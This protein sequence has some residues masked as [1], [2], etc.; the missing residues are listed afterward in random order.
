MIGGRQNRAGSPEPALSELRDEIVAHSG[1]GY[2]PCETATQTVPGDGNPEASVVFVGE[3]PGKNE[4]EQGRPFIGR[5]GKLLDELLAEAGLVR[6]DVWITNVVKA[7]PPKNRDPKAPEIAHW[8]PFLEREL[9][10][11]QPQ[12]IVPLGRHAL[13]H[14]APT[15]KIG[16]V[17]GTL[18]EAR[19][20]PL[21]HPAA[22]MY[23]QTLKSTLFEDA[24]ALGALLSR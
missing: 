18:I 5:A 2:E 11:I 20:F 9:E 15:A 1:C 12:L 16:E 23:N 22:A 19:V 21:Y 24:R 17:H 4:D 3:A 14:F 13:K 7:R 8:M 6:A 10:L